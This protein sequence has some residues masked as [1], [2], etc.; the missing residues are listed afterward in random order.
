M[1]ARYIW[2]RAT[3]T[4]VD[5]AVYYAAKPRAQRSHLSAPS[6]H[7]DFGDYVLC[8]ADGKRYSSKGAY[9]QAL[10]DNGCIEIGTE[11]YGETPRSD[12]EPA[13]LRDDIKRAMWENGHSL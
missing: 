4:L 2:D 9:R 7:G 8:H 12:P 11:K 6:I 3:M 13:G 5:P 10:K 1:K